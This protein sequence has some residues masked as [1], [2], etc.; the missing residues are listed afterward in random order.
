MPGTQDLTIDQLITAVK[1]LPPTQLHVFTRRLSAWQVKSRKEDEETGLIATAQARLPATVE[2]RF[3]R[4]AGK[5]ERGL[6]SAKELEEYRVLAQQAEQLNAQRVE[7]LAKLARR[8][9]KPVRVVMREIGGR[10]G[11]DDAASRSPRRSSVGA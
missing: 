6:L 11:E 8:W 5:S 2:R 10:E 4:L 1:R 9:G 3:R 7:A